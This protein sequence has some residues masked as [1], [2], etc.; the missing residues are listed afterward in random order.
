[1]Q[2]ASTAANADDATVLREMRQL[3]LNLATFVRPAMS[4]AL[5]SAP[6]SFC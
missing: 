5:P 3:W 6:A 4:A 2:L 1:M